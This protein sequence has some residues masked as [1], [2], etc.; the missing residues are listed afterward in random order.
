VEYFRLFDRALVKF[1]A[2]LAEDEEASALI[3][4]GLVA[5]REAIEELE[6]DG[7]REPDHDEYRHLATTG[8]SEPDSR[9]IFD[10]V[11]Q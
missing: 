8:L 11:D 7:P 5:I 2:A 6:S 3:E 10:D 4:Q 1:G 9:S